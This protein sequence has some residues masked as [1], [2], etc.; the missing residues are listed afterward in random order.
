M[1]FEFEHVIGAGPDSVAAVSLDIDYQRSV[2][3]VVS[4]YLSERT[5][6]SQ[7][8]RTDGSVM[9]EIR[10]V[11]GIALP[12][13]ARR[14]IGD[15]DPAWVEHAVYTPDELAWRWIVEP[16]VGRGLLKAGGTITFGD[17]A[18]GTLRRV[19][20]DVAFRVPV[21]GGRVEEIVVDHLDKIYDVEARHLAGW[22]E[23][24]G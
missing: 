23:S 12:G 8:E 21:Y 3:A 24:T 13:G 1:R 17:H 20:G 14:F 9:R 4:D 19:A 16:E 5:V 22:L 18:D 15:K 11:L 10:C 6:L 7:S 2:E